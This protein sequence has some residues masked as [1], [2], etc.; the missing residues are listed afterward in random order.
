MLNKK[1]EQRNIRKLLRLANKLLL[2]NK[3][4]TSIPILIIKLLSFPADH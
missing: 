4:K 3:R 1:N 2:K